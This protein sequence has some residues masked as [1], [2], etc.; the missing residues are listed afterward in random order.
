MMRTVVF[1]PETAYQLV[2]AAERAGTAP[3]LSP[4]RPRRRSRS[5]LAGEGVDYS[6]W[7]FGFK[8]VTIPGQNE[9]P[10]TSGVEITP[11][12]VRIHGAGQWSLALPATVS[13][14]PISEPWVYAQMS[15]GGGSVTIAVSSVEPVSNASTLK[16]PL[17]LFERLEGGTYA[18]HSTLGGIRHIGDINLDTPLL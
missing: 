16:I 4:Y 5:R 13:L 15:R 12:T 11:G 7:A 18:L 14:D 10:S 2:Q 6:K 3:L 8:R 17:Y 1:K 9:D